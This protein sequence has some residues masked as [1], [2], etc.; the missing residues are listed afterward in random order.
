MKDNKQLVAAIICFALAILVG[1]VMFTG[2]EGVLA[3]WLLLYKYTPPIVTVI[4]A[5]FAALGVYRNP[6]DKAR[7][8]MVGALVGV[9]FV[10]LLAQW[11][12]P[13]WII[14]GD[15]LQLSAVNILLTCI[16]ALSIHHRESR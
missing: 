1:L 3:R 13:W 8:L 9:A 16:I 4:L 5:F 10:Y 7:L 14:Y 2:I 15:S 12:P 11:S 6:Q